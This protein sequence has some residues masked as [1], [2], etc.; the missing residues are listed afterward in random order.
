MESHQKTLIGWVFSELKILPDLSDHLTHPNDAQE[1]SSSLTDSL[2]TISNESS[3]ALEELNEL[4][5]PEVEIDEIRE[6]SIGGSRI[7]LRERIKG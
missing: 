7:L 3:N 1:N 6:H 4:G 2:E 5:T